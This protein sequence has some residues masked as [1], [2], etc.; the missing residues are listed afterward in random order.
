MVVVR[1]GV[2]IRWWSFRSRLEVGFL[3]LPGWLARGGIAARCRS[4]GSCAGFVVQQVAGFRGSALI[5]LVAW[6][7]FAAEAAP[8]DFLKIGNS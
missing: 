3:V 7:G 6:A 5:R 2:R 4:Y 8:T 1:W